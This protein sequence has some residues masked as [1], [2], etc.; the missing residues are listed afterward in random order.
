MKRI[1]VY[2]LGSIGDTVIAL[3][4]FKLIR[5]SYPEHE[6]L[7]LTNVPVSGNTA[8][9]LSV[10][11][12]D[13]QLVDGAIEYPVSTRSVRVLL[14]LAMQLRSL[15]ADTLI[16]LMSNR[17]ALLAW[18]DWLFFKL[19]GFVNIVG[20][21]YKRNLRK[22]IIDEKNQ[23]VEREAFRLIR[24]IN[25]LGHIEVDNP[26]VWD[27]SLSVSER[28]R[29]Q[30]FIKDLIKAPYFSINI[31]GKDPIKDW[32][33]GNW[34]TLLLSLKQKYPNF[35]LLVVGAAS[36]FESAQ[37]LLDCWSSP[38]ANSCGKLTPRESAAAMEKS[39]LFIGHDS[40]PLHLASAVGLP[41]IGLFGNHNLP[42]RWHPYSKVSHVIHNMKGV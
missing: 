35:G 26:S 42:S 10:L 22:N 27:L 19:T 16:Y 28:D 29:G 24:C 30:A 34:Q 12:E 32:G 33:L 1:L 15:K 31:G 9:L 37:L 18:R 21:P 20:F 13:G 6:I 23:T 39:I 7:V 40:G 8:P 4:C 41:T 5:S 25:K 38:T 2:R 3:P 11:G 14:S 17:P 36:D